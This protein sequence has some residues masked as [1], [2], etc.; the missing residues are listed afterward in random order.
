MKTFTDISEMRR[1]I[2]QARAAGKTVGLMPTLGGMHKA[3]FSLVDA[4]RADCDVVV[5]SIFLNPT[6][7]GPNEDLDAYPRTLEADCA[8]CE[9]RGVDAVFAPSVEA[10]YGQGGLTEVRVKE[11]SETLCGRHRPIHFAG[12]CAVVLKLFNI[13]QPHKAY[14]GAKDYQQA[15]VIRRMV[16]DLN[17]PVEIVVCPI[18]READGL[19]MSTRNQYLNAE[20]RRQAAALYGSLQMAAEMIHASRPPAEQVAA[21]IRDYLASHAPLG[22]IDY[23]QIVN[24]DTL[25]DVETTDAP[26]VIALAVQFGAARLIDNVRVDTGAAA[27]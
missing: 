7:F 23:V 6:Q 2:E 18:V 9:A 5:V 16:A 24:P 26:V 15:T 11:L 12:V 20:Q 14:F 1:F 13:V 19:A 3:H 22:Q 4:A 17:V 27:T 21:A 10:M 25:A 8:A